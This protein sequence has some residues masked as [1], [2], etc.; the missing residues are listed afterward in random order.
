MSGFWADLL[1]ALHFGFVAFVVGGLAII[2]VGAW[3]GW[4]W[5]LNPY[6]RYTHLAAIAFVAAEALLGIACPLTIWEDRLRGAAT[7]QSFMERW[8]GRALYYDFPAWI[9][10]LAYVS[11]AALV[12][13]VLWRIPPRS[14]SK[15]L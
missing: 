11:F 12:A 3:R 5:I 2:L 7:E 14:R 15:P 6:F 8:I 4:Q 9:F 1:L 13:Y 10:T